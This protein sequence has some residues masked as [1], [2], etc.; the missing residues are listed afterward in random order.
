MRVP[1]PTGECG[2]A[3]RVGA[4]G[5]EEGACGG[6]QDER[7]GHSGPVPGVCDACNGCNVRN[8][9]TACN[10][11]GAPSRCPSSR[12][13][14]RRRRS[15]PATAS[16]GACM[17]RLLRRTS[18]P[19]TTLSIRK[20]GHAPACKL[21]LNPRRARH[22]GCC[23]CLCVYCVL[24]LAAVTVTGSRLGVA[25]LGEVRHEVVA[26]TDRRAPGR[27][28]RHTQET[29]GQSGLQ[30]THTRRVR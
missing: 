23:S 10:V 6:R 14:G 12:R 3:A 24:L 8:A 7:W 25:Q 11:C 28:G 19:T 9:C 26:Q 22:P 5:E 29:S 17:L 30:C 21:R 2:A 15:R 27:G 18:V 16:E 13:F 1:Y 20:V 4:M